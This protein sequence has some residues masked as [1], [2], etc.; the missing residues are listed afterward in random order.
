[1]KHALT[2]LL[3]M[4]GAAQATP[5]K[6]SATTTIIADIVK[7]VG[8]NRVTVNTIVPSGADAHAFQPSTGA[9]RSLAS[10]KVLF[11]NGAGLEP[12]LPQLKAAAPKVPIKTML[13]TN[14]IKPLKLDG[15][16]DPHAWWNLEN[17]AEYARIIRDTLTALDPA[18]KQTY[19]DNQN[20]YVEEMIGLDA[21]ASRQIESI[22]TG[23]RKIITNHESLNYF[24]GR[25]G[26]KVV[27]VVF[28]G[29]GT[30]REPSARELAQLIQTVKKS[31]ARVIFTENTVNA[32]L[33]QTLARE[34]GAKIAPPL[35]TDALGPKGSA[36]DTF[37][38]AFKYNVN[39]IVKALK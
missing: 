32:R 5:L 18:G 11:A 38:K 6:V 26:L 12:W 34:T 4:I 24:A 8:G 13:P 15:A 31:G 25:Y 9:I 36:G 37:L 28:P 7:N 21:W 2:A 29:L 27:G 16:T 10:S 39:T 19:A 14:N 1:M 3:I 35:Y 30:E 23:K 22:P 20:G 17:A 33:A